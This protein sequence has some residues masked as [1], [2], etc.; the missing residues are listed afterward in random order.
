MDIV[1]QFERFAADFE[2]AVWDDDWSRLERYLAEG[3]TYVNIGGPD[4]K[5][6]GRSAILAFLKEDVANS[7]RR[8][9]S[10][11]LVAL[12][13]PIA[14]GERLSRRWRCTYS[15]AGAPDLIVEG[16]ARYR[17]D[18]G[19]IQAIEEEVTPDSMQAVMAWMQTYG[20][21]LGGP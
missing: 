20:D 13:P 11:T 16:E 2:A 15:L 6:E 3:A 18:G 19:L 12:T 7:D 17:F 21:R 9:D 1:E 4:P 5:C 14:D 10:R 8:F